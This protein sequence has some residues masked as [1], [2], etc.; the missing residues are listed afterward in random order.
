MS[1]ETNSLRV[2]WSREWRS[3][4]VRLSRWLTSTTYNKK[5]LL[6]GVIIGII[7]GLGAIAFYE[8]LRLATYFFLEVL[9]GYR[10]PLPISEGARAA[11]AG[12]ARPWA[13]PLVACVGALA[14][15]ILVF[16]VAPE[17]EGHGTDAAIAAV[18]HNPRGVRVRA[19]I[20]KIIASALTIGS[21]G[22]GGREGP[23]GQISA[24]FGSF[25]ARFLDLSP[26]DARITVASGI[27]SGIGAIFGAPLGGAIL[28][29]EILYRDDFE[30]EALLPSFIASIVGYAVWG[31]V[32]GFGPLFGYVGNY[33]LTSAM[34]L[35]W[36]AIIGI[37][38]GGVGLLYAKTFYAMADYF[39]RLPLARWIR[40]ALGGLI[41]GLIALAIPEV[42]GT[43]YGWI[44]A[45]LGPQLEHIPL[46]IVLILPFARIA[47]TGLSIGSGGSGGI[48]GPGMVI[49][50]FVGAAVWRLLEP[51]VPSLGHDPAPF[52]I[53]GMM[54]C[55]GSISRAPLAVMLMVAEMT[56]TLSLVVPA[57]LAVGLATLIVRRN[58]DT[59]YRSQLRSRI[60][61]P[62]HRIL[63][64]LPLL[65]LVPAGDA[66][67]SPRCV[68]KESDQPST[69]R[70]HLTAANVS[71][72]PVV[73]AQGRYLGVVNLPEVDIERGADEKSPPT[74]LATPVEGAAP[75]SVGAI[76][77]TYAPIHQSI[78]LD[79]VLETL[80]STTQRWAAVIDDDRRVVGTISISDIVRNY[81]RTVQANLQRISELGGTTGIS[82]FVIN[83][84]S[85]MVGRSVRTSH[86]PRGVLIT[87]I[88]RGRD[89]IRPT[90]D[91]TLKAGD[92][93][94][95]LGATED[96]EVL[97]QLTSAE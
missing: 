36:F 20:V 59:I 77:A 71:A 62:A 6:L 43:G 55:F 22:S 45:G 7:A 60:E 87:A 57:M 54:A 40:P 92:R 14:G 69:M 96:L 25:L 17:A 86:T 48:F 4:Q 46:W 21:G 32:E 79:S 72:A 16:A 5:W 76:D 74:G 83:E 18:H 50:A 80:T 39:S 41:V 35:L 47:T 89:V 2:R 44:Q 30:V 78:H 84:Q 94:T 75:E 23:T 93:L 24:G 85:S 67:A 8:A 63:T 33:H 68:L 58:D 12:F 95:V 13:I 34:Q 53:V 70:E 38:G 52:V 49:G 81:R 1:P 73:D 61:S 66:M 10:V 28:A 31:S 51:V 42:I 65:A 26:A 91:T 9:A 19:V 11:S 56:G 97:R 64:G 37:I 82:E 90:G 15:A 88:E 27:G 29:T 3:L